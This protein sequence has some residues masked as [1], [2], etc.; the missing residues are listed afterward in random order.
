[1][2]DAPEVVKAYLEAQTALIALTEDRLW[3]NRTMPIEGYL[4]SQGHALVFRPRG[5][6]IL[7]YTG[8]IYTQSWMFKAYGSSEREADLLWRTLFDVFNEAKS[9]GI[10]R[11]ALELGGQPLQEPVTGWD[12]SLSYWTILLQTM[13]EPA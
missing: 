2:I 11:V 6:G 7:D 3:P 10:Y 13:Y 9:A 5:A 1:M 4:P 8:H 12:Y